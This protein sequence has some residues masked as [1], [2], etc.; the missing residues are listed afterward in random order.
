[1]TVRDYLFVTHYVI[2][3]IVLSGVLYLLIKYIRGK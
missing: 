1:M 2:N 3:L